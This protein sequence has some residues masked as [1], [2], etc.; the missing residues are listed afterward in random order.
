MDKKKR[1]PHLS[2][3]R[4]ALKSLGNSFKQQTNPSLDNQPSV[5]KQKHIRGIRLSGTGAVKAR[6]P[7]GFVRTTT[8]QPDPWW[9]ETDVIKNDDAGEVD[10]GEA[11]VR[12]E[13]GV[14]LLS[15]EKLAIKLLNEKSITM[16]RR[17]LRREKDNRRFKEYWAIDENG[18]RFRYNDIPRNLIPLYHVDQLNLQEA[19]D[20]TIVEST[21]PADKLNSLG[22]LAVGTITGAFI[23]PSVSALT[24]LLRA[25]RIYLW[26]DNDSVGTRHMNLI[27]KR[28]HE[29]DHKDI[30]IIRWV[31]GPRKGDAFDFDGDATELSA[32]YDQAQQ[33][34]PDQSVSTGGTL[35]LRKQKS[36]MRLKLADGLKPPMPTIHIP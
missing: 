10:A 16:V 1:P 28:L 23:A 20:V 11:G 33:W 3:K 6:L 24:P 31:D 18:V 26:P 35:T 17:V 32:L 25:R 22:K 12:F 30:R 9:T 8:F 4:F 27:A 36:P 2:K 19:D 29:M 13:N 14:K 5:L 7:K 15:E 21:G 34:S